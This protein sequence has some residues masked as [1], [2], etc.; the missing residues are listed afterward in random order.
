[1]NWA[2][3]VIISVLLISTLLS[4]WRGFVRE[5]ISLAT[6]F[7]SIAVAIVFR[8]GMAVFL[9]PLIANP[10][11]R[12]IVAFISLFVMAMI[13]G[14]VVGII[15]RRLIKAAGMSGIDR[16]LGMAFGIVRGVMV[17]ALAVGLLS[18]SNFVQD[19]IWWKTSVLIPHFMLIKDFSQYVGQVIT[20]QLI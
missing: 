17:V 11:G 14:S 12:S 7:L 5:A 6:W 2:D 20:M 3:W 19:F 15:V 4:L 18:W 10:A 9:E 13:V 8:P 1:M 16:T